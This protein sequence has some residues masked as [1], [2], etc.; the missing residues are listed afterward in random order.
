MRSR[1]L[2]VLLAVGLVAGCGGTTGGTPRAQPT[3]PITRG[4]SEPATTT[5]PTTSTFPP[6]PREIPLE[7][8]DPCPLWTKKQLRDFGVD[9]EPAGSGPTPNGFGGMVCH[10]FGLDGGPQLAYGI[11]TYPEDDLAAT[12]RS[13]GPGITPVPVEVAGFPAVQRRT[14]KGAARCKV[15]IGTATGQHLNVSAEVT[16]NEM[17]IEESCELSMTAATLA[18]ENL[19]KLY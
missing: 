16:P 14:S 17:S 9:E 5:S 13:M 15:L 11:N 2:L 7:D 6:P 3:D 19:Q 8:V 10:Y 4:T 1:A 12:A 18:M